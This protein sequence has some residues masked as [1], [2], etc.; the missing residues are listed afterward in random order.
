MT[1]VTVG[2]LLYG[3]YTN[4][5]ERCLSPLWPLQRSGLI[6]LRIGCNAVSQSTLDYL[7]ANGAYDDPRV[8][9]IVSRDNIHKYPMIRHLIGL[10]PLAPHFM[11]FD[12]DS[13]VSHPDPAEF[14]RTAL[15]CCTDND[16][17][18][19]VWSIRLGGNQH[20]WVR[21]QP[22]YK[23]KPVER[24][25]RVL[26]CQGAWWTIKS[27]ILYRFDWPVPELVRKG[28]DVM[29]GELC[30]QQDL[31][32]YDIR[33]HPTDFG[34]RINADMQGQHSRMPTRGPLGAADTNRT[35]IP[36]GWNYQPGATARVL[37]TI[38]DAPQ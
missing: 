15:S 12:D 9:L 32:I 2:V 37:D 19:Q 31:K 6:Q 24:G 35:M 7:R 3:D 27:S 25:H 4:L 11:W 36:I 18:G 5:A 29:L 10:A 28:G 21:D 14:V 26:F 8:G 17:V 34:V 20:L 38:G 23:G 13:Y 22:W 33:K 16:M 1:C 30:R